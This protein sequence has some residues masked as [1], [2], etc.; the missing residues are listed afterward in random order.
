M[1]WSEI[2]ED[3]VY[4][5]K[6]APPWLVPTKE[7]FGFLGVFESFSEYM[8]LHVK[9]IQRTKLRDKKFSPFR[10]RAMHLEKKS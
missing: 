10:T 4:V 3:S 1:Q 5:N 2:L 8:K 6:E 9:D 7:N